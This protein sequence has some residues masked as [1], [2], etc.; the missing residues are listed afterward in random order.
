LLFGPG[1]ALK[2]WG[3]AGV[4]GLGNPADTAFF[5]R[6]L[7]LLGLGLRA[8]A[9]ASAASTAKPFVDSRR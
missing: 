5:E 8:E 6:L 4:E 7:H 1:R 2:A 9:A 3:A